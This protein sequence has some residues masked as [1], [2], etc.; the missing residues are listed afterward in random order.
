MPFQN[1]VESQLTQ[2]QS[3]V[4]GKLK[5]YASYNL[6][7][8]K[9][10]LY[11]PKNKQ[12]SLFDYMK[13][14]FK[15]MGAGAAFDNLLKTFLK[16]LFDPA[17]KFLE[18]KII[19][20]IAHSLDAQGKIL[21]QG[22]TNIDWLTANVMPTLDLGKE[23]IFG[24]LMAL[25]FGPPPLMLSQLAKSKAKAGIGTPAMSP[26][27][28]LQMA[29]C[30]QM[31]YSISNLPDEGVGDLEY[32]KIRLQNQL[33]TGGIVFEISCQEVIIKM[34]ET[35][36]N[37][38]MVDSVG[39]IPGSTPVF[40][41]TYSINALDS[42]VQHEVARQ[43]VPE[44]QTDASKTFWEGFVTKLLNLITTAASAQLDP[45]FDLITVNANPVQ[46]IVDS[47]T[48]VETFVPTTVTKESVISDP[49]SIYSDGLDKMSTG[50][51]TNNK[52]SAFT[53]FLLNA[54]LGL[55]LSILLTELLKLLKKLLK[56]ILAKKSADLA[57]RL[58]KKRM[59]QFESF[60]GEVS[61][62]AK[63][64][65]KLAQALIKLKPILSLFINK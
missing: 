15:S 6:Y 18:N 60:Q 57:K 9:V 5:A 62:K 58:L 47:I 44:N 23:Q 63:R 20:G 26:D 4:L 59:A 16:K 27:S 11:I 52:K 31:L 43:N 35:V 3:E 53:S 42:Y 34:P 29:S 8:P 21:S 41:P 46:K 64:L 30:G 54:V 32:K 56:N 10:D 28:I 49:C 50:N 36:L 19:E 45:I 12:I 38:I 33:A 25:I 2:A 39:T 55:L 13:K 65:E 7:V 51:P 48:G 24:F 40:N 1:Q 37:T 17:S 22:T 14:L 61:A